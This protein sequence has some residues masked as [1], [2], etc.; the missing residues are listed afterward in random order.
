MANP[1]PPP[2]RPQAEP[3][4]APWDSGLRLQPSA[5]RLQRNVLED[6]GWRETGGGGGG[7]GWEAGA[8]EGSPLNLQGKEGR[9]E[10]EADSAGLS[11]EEPGGQ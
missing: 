1:E 10:T 2:P 11:H 5:V 6:S 3:E 8:G 9:R 4:L 7:C